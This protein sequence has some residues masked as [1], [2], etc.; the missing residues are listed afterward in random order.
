MGLRVSRTASEKLILSAITA[1]ALCASAGA[2]AVEIE[3]LGQTEIPGDLEVDHT[4]VGGLSGLAYDPGCDLYY[5]LSDDRGSFGMPRFFTLRVTQ[6]GDEVAVEV[7]GAT[8]LQDADGSPFSG[9]DLDAE[10]IAL[11]ADGTLFLATEGVPH[12]GVEPVLAMFGLDG[13]LRGTLPVPEHYLPAASGSR[14][15]R[16]NLGFEGLALSPDGAL[17]FAATENALLQDGPAADLETGSPARLLVI[18]LQESAVQAEYLYVVGPV[19]D[20]PRPAAAFRTNGISEI[21]ALDRHRL[22]MFERSFSAGVG[23]RGRLYLADLEGASDIHETAALAAVGAGAPRPVTKVLVADLADFGI[24]PDNLESIALGPALADGRRLLVMMADNNFQPSVQDNQV[25]VFAVS[26][27]AGPVVE[28]FRPKVHDIQGAGHFSPSVGRCVVGVEGVVT[29]ILG[30]RKGQAFWIQGLVSDQDPSTSEGVLVTAL[31]GAATVAVGDMVRVD[32]RVEERSWGLELPVTRIVASHLEVAGDDFPLPDPVVIGQGGVPIPR[33]EVASRQ[34]RVFDP[35][36]YAADAFETLEGM[37]VRLDDG[38]V[39]GPTSKHGEFVVVPDQGRG[40]GPWTSRGGLRM[41]PCNVHPQRVAIDD[42]LVKNPPQVAVGDR[43]GDPIE[44][45]LHY[46]Y[47][48]YKVLNTGPLGPVSQEAPD[49]DT[50]GVFPNPDRFTAATFNVENLWAGSDPEKFQRLGAII[51]HN[52]T[53]PDILAVQEIQDDSGATDDGTVSANETLDRLVD[54]IEAAGGVRYEWRTVDPADNTN[55]GHPGANIRNA[56]LFNSERAQ[57]VDRNWCGTD[58]QAVI[59]EGLTLDC[60]PALLDP[61]NRVFVPDSNGRGG[62]RKPLA[63]EFL[64]DGETYFFVNLHLAS[65][66]G[67][68]PIFG[69]RQPRVTGSTARRTAQAEVVARWVRQVLSLDPETRVVVLGDLNDFENTEPLAALEDAGLEDLVLRLPAED[70]YSY[71]YLGN[72]QVLDHVLVSPALKD[73]VDVDAIHVNADIP[74]AA[75]ASDHDPIVV[76]F[77]RPLK[78]FL[79]TD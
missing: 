21:V 23:N 16:D 59:A 35:S 58:Q 27:V 31:E 26:G 37:R 69:R 79:E 28:A 3:F 32:G 45:I 22:L 40:S 78:F 56:F 49:R 62:S 54:A 13:S 10:A 14:G 46:S 53:S 67:D 12:R 70:R 66:G 75:R 60:S 48:S 4:R 17:L 44:G 6:R 71:V 55:G 25:L 36:R 64:I 68:D 72:S 65:K 73:M 1:I 20:E 76:G 7:L 50:S 63:G 30:Q 24:A 39:V 52:L 42:A 9:G 57:F 18:N 51:A 43:L 74:A 38:L 15:V 34:L 33:G 61:T 5:A 29:A 19:P 77:T 8:V 2:P 11:S 41:T 47:G